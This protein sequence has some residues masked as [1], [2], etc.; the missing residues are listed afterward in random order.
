MYDIYI[1]FHDKINILYI[2]YK[3]IYNKLFNFQQKFG[4]N[5]YW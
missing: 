4:F 2:K 1:I 3:K 5:E